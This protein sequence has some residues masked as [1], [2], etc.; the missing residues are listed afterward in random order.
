MTDIVQSAI[1]VI[2]KMV[3]NVTWL[4]T[5]SKQLHN[6]L[7]SSLTCWL[8]SLGTSTC[9]IK[10]VVDHMLLDLGLVWTYGLTKKV[11]CTLKTPM[12]AE[13][14][15]LDCY[16]AELLIRMLTDICTLTILMEADF[17]TPVLMQESRSLLTIM[18]IFTVW[19]MMAAG[20]TLLDLIKAKMSSSTIM[21][22]FMFKILMVQ[23]LI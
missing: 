11:I 4:Q 9:S 16:K 19:M 14:T 2:I 12:E 8:I 7:M 3:E 20:I 23:S 18:D 15:W 22:T 6:L 1:Q 10:M 5:I 17:I 21:D 13:D